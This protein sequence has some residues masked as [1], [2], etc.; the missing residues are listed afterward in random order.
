MVLNYS[1][2][3]SNKDIEK[4]FDKLI[5]TSRELMDNVEELKIKMAGGAYRG[6]PTLLLRDEIKLTK[7]YTFYGSYNNITFYCCKNILKTLEKIYDILL[8]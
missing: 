1:L 8:K 5:G 7:K 3:H 2:I 6:S 4:L